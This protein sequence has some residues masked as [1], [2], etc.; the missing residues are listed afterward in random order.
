MLVLNLKTAKHS[1]HTLLSAYHLNLIPITHDCDDKNE[2]R[3]N[4]N[5]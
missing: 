2:N 4:F 5:T 1:E 3:G